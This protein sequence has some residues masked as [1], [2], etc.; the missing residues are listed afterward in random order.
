MRRL[1]TIVVC[2]LACAVPAGADSTIPQGGGA[3]NVV[4]ATATGID[5]TTR[6]RTSVQV[7][8]V[9]SDNLANTN[10][11]NA[12]SFN[13]DG[14]HAAA[15]AVQVIVVYGSPQ[16]VTPGNAAVAT[17]AGCFD[18]RSYAYA[19]QYAFQ[20]PGAFV[21]S[22][23]GRAE[24]AQLEQEMT[25]ALEVG[26][27]WTKAAADALTAQLDTLAEQLVDVI[28]ADLLAAGLPPTESF[29]VRDVQQQ[30]AE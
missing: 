26:D 11:A 24:V 20:V 8:L 17:N 3:A 21:L 14:C 16:F 27:P 9:P 18:C 10:F 25:D 6:E 23:T 2:A 19:S 15:V 28:K 7:T 13:C 4:N 22:P 29:A 1:L 5:G 12:L 30:P